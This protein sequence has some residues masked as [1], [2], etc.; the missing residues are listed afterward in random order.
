MR[1][2]TSGWLIEATAHCPGGP[3]RPQRYYVAVPI[4]AEAITALRR[5]VPEIADANIEAVAGLSP[6]TVYGRLHLKRGDI[7][8][9]TSSDWKEHIDALLDEGL[10]ETFPCSDPVAAGSFTGTEPSPHRRGGKA[11][12]DSTRV[13]RAKTAKDAEG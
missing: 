3:F 4:K 12:T 13:H 11:S 7:A 2:H 5:R 10:E 6:H 1:S 8:E 9:A